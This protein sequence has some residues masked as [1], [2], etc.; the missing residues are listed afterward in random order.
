MSLRQVFTDR[1]SN[2]YLSGKI[3]VTY[4]RQFFPTISLILLTQ[5]FK[6]WSWYVLSIEYRTFFIFIC[7][8][9]ITMEVRKLSDVFGLQVGKLLILSKE[10]SY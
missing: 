6:L 8:D 3:M 10:G 7:A 4:L 1:G 2:A 5:I 9:I